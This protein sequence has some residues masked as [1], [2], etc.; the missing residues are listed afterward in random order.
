M[1]RFAIQGYS[2][3]GTSRNVQFVWHHDEYI[4]PVFEVPDKSSS[5]PCLMPS[6]DRRSESKTEA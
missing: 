4:S 6:N 2:F 1:M 5:G 3:K